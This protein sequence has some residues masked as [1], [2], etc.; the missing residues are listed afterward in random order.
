MCAHSPVVRISSRRK[1]FALSR[2]GMRVSSLRLRVTTWGP[3][4]KRLESGSFSA[5]PYFTSVATSREALPLSTPRNSATS[6]TDPPSGESARRERI[7]SPRARDWISA[8]SHLSYVHCTNLMHIMQLYCIIL[9][10]S[11]LSH[12]SERSAIERK[13]SKSCPLCFL[14]R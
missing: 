9:N 10:Y 13:N 14:T 6:V 8:M 11:L 7:L 3:S 2:K 1:G 4:E 5:K 12:D